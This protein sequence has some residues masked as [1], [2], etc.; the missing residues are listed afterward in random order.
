[1]SAKIQE[2]PIPARRATARGKEPWD[3]TEYSKASDV[4]PW[5]TQALKDAWKSEWNV[6]GIPIGYVSG[7]F[8]SPGLKGQFQIVGPVSERSPRPYITWFSPWSNTQWNMYL[9]QVSTKYRNTTP[10]KNR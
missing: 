9:D 4:F 5:L 3:G 10:V 7:L 8:M 1:M 6:S 2:L